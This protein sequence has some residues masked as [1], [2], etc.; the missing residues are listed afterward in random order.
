M[1]PKEQGPIWHMIS[2]CAPA[3]MQFQNQLKL[4][5]VRKGIILEQILCIKK[6]YARKKNEIV[7]A[8]HKNYKI[9]ENNVNLFGNI[10]HKPLNH[11]KQNHLY[12]S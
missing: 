1:A 3:S 7:F 2:L 4:R 8:L 10:V 5:K 12:F 6:T 11:G 9:Y